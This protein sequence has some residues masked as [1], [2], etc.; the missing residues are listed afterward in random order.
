MTPDKLKAQ[1]YERLGIGPLWISR[2]SPDPLLTEEPQKRQAPQPVPE[3]DTVARP[4][5]LWRE[6][7]SKERPV[8]QHGA[9]REV[10]DVSQ[11]DLIREKVKGASWEELCGLIAGCAACRELARSRTST[12]PGILGG[13]GGILL[14]GEAPGR[15]EDLMGEP[16]VGKSGKLLD[17][18]LSAFGLTRGKEV[19]IIN[20]LKCRPPNNR[21]PLPQEAAACGCFLARQIELA[22]PEKI[23]LLGKSAARAVL[24]SEA[25]MSALRGKRHHIESA[26]REVPVFVTYHPSFLLRSPQQ[27]EAAWRDFLF[28]LS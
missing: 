14:I 9:P 4:A 16:F 10:P 23:I 6:N 2:S 21:D 22:R 13:T 19:S 20:V 5:A 8:G 28:A 3:P 7:F 18:I 17:N 25:P 15:D 11:N 26:G 1:I 24:S 27:K 12:V